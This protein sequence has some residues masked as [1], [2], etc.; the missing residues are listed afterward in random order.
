VEIERVVCQSL[1]AQT[2][3]TQ[4]I[5]VLLHWRTIHG[6]ETQPPTECAFCGDFGMAL[7]TGKTGS[8]DS[9]VRQP[10]FWAAYDRNLITPG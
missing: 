6:S 4:P 5:Q 3:L 7:K 9:L 2:L 10:S 1:Q 8:V